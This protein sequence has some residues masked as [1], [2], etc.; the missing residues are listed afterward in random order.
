MP[1][2]G[3]N[4]K[5]QGNIST[6]LRFAPDSSYVT[7]VGPK[8]LKTFSVLKDHKGTGVISSLMKLKKYGFSSIA[9]SKSGN[10]YAGGYDGKVYKFQNSSVGK[11]E[12]LHK[13]MVMCV[14]VVIKEN[15]EVLVS[16]D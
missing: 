15:K 4:Y 10:S 6:M 2:T 5:G 11:G 14:N 9:F 1:K 3:F 12:Q 8:H 13:K 16:G 7:A